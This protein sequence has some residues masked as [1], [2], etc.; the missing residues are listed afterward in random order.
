M[1][2]LLAAHPAIGAID[3]PSVPENEG[4]Y[5]QGAIP[6][7][8]LHGVPGHYATDPDQ[9]HVEGSRYDTLETAR[10]LRA[11]WDRWFPPDARWRI[12]KS[13]VNLTRMRLYQQ[14]FPMAHFVVILR[15][16]RAMAAALARWSDRDHDALVRYGLDAYDRAMDDARRLHCVLILRYEDLVLAPDRTLAAVFAFL[17]LDPVPPAVPLRDGN[18]VY[19]DAP[20]FPAEL[21]DRLA[22][23]GYGRN[24]GVAH[25]FARISHPLR[26][27]REMVRELI[28]AEA[29][30]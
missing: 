8:A 20:P 28:G 2:R 19:A 7:T 3:H 22:R 21:R 11:D 16:P 30:A 13:P 6:H 12:E 10:R 4:C 15:H 17:G 23:Y 29:I 26:A 24:G 9:H 5:L 18:A 25:P 1:T 27:R 14:L